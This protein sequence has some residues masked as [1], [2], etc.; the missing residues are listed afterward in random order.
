M[1]PHMHKSIRFTRQL[2]Y[3]DD[4][5][6]AQPW[7][8][9]KSVPKY[10]KIAQS[11]NNTVHPVSTPVLAPISLSTSAVSGFNRKRRV[12]SDPVNGPTSKRSKS[13]KNTLLLFLRG[14]E[15]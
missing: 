8:M 12:S 13:H 9:E 4:Q 15:S 3:D 14:L 1:P 10:V 2:P 5:F 6:K 11:N 7:S